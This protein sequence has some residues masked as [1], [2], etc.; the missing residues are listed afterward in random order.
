MHQI[1][2]TSR[3]TKRYRNKKETKN[4]IKFSINTYVLERGIKLV[5]IKKEIQ[6]NFPKN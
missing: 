1:M 5:L 4:L 3:I 2:L 6:I